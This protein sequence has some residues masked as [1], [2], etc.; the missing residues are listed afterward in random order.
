[1][2]SSTEAE[3]VGVD[4]R[5]P[6]VLWTRYFLQEQGYEMRPSLIYQDSKSTML[7]EQNGKASSSKRTKHI[8]VRYFFVKDKIAK[9]EIELE[10]CSTKVMWADMN[11]KPKQGREWIIFRYMLMGIPENYNDQKEGIARAKAMAKRKKEAEDLE[12][13]ETIEQAVAMTPD[14]LQECVGE[15]QNKNVPPHVNK[16]HKRR[17]L[18]L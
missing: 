4:D 18:P 10:H 6:L 7:L 11:T 12:H 8:N 9:G 14:Q 13:K 15:N 16:R 17:I 1:V 3:V 2:K 5:L